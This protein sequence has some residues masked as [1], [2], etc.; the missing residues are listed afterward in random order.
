MGKSAAEAG[1]R[2]LPEQKLIS[3]ERSSWSSSCTASQKC[4]T[5]GSVGETDSYRVA[6]CSTAMST[7]ASPQKIPSNSVGV[8]MGSSSAG[9]TLLSPRTMLCSPCA[10]CVR[11]SCRARSTRRPAAEEAEVE[12]EADSVG[13]G[14]EAADR[15]VCC[16][17]A[18]VAVGPSA[19]AE[20]PPAA[21]EISACSKSSDSSPPLS[22]A[23]SEPV[24]AESMA[25]RS[26]TSTASPESARHS[27][28]GKLN[29]TRMLCLQAMATRRPNCT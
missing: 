26:D 21:A 2:D 16:T 1:R 5:C 13:A 11:F 4:S 29:A 17:S 24:V 7:S 18:R 15:S 12:E 3:W 9:T 19:E 23:L 28:R 10:C 6:C 27:R 25:S 22:M 8:N 20:E 14:V